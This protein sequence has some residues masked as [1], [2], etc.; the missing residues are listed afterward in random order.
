MKQ[1]GEYMLYKIN[2]GFKI[3]KSTRYY[4]A[5][6]KS[7]KMAKEILK[8]NVVIENGNLI[9]SQNSS[10]LIN[11]INV[12]LNNENIPNDNHNYLNNNIIE[13][14][15]EDRFE[16]ELLEIIDEMIKTNDKPD[17]LGFACLLLTGFFSAKMTQNCLSIVLKIINFLIDAKIPKSFDELAQIILNKNNDK[18]EYDKKWYCYMCK[19]YIRIEDDKRQRKCPDCSER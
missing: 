3:P 10:L 1:R 19:K 7:N 18:I 15:A 11:E 5:K 16:N 2:P 9:Q 8:K 17:K 14:V 13:T 4:L 6:K 12:N